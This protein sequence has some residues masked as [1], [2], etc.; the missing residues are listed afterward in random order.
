VQVKR[1][2]TLIELLVVIAI[3][4]ILAAIL[5]PVF[6]K[7]R[8]KARSTQ[9]LSN[10]R[11]LAT[12]MIQYTEDWGGVTPDNDIPQSQAPPG[13]PAN[14][15]ITDHDGW[16]VHIWPYVKN[17]GIFDCPTSPDY[18]NKNPV[19]DYDG[20][21]GWAEESCDDTKDRLDSDLAPAAQAFL[22]ADCGDGCFDKDDDLGAMLKS[23]GD[24][25][26]TNGE[27]LDR[28]NGGTNM[29]F[30]DGHAKWISRGQLLQ[31]WHRYEAPWFVK[32]D[33]EVQPDPADVFPG[34][35]I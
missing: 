27:N 32:W 22:I 9:C 20:N 7:A 19:N 8:E 15:T 12:A 34:R 33:N 23:D 29:A 21:Y 5:F 4:A 17:I 14:G 26:K 24:S 10:L 16:P 2:F 30:R 31:G 11:Q 3:I 6:A 1:G 18:A 28:H 13:W 25:R 35:T